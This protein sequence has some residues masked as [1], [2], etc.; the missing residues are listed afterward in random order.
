MKMFSREEEFS[1]G[2]IKKQKVL[3][4][5]SGKKSRKKSRYIA[6]KTKQ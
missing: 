2:K 6:M 5:K 3:R 1:V 4:K